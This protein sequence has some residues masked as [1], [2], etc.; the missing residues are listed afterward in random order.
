M[1]YSIVFW[2]IHRFDSPIPQIIYKRGV[3]IVDSIG[4]AMMLGF[5]WFAIKALVVVYFMI[6]MYRMTESLIRISKILEMSI[7]KNKEVTRL[8]EVTQEKATEY[9][10]NES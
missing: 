10:T 5:V 6:L 3:V 7:D 4:T 2:V 9:E 1:S 8:N